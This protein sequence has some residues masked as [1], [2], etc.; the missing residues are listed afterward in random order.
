LL[1]EQ[2]MV[3]AYIEMKLKQRKYKL[4]ADDIGKLYKI[5]KRS[6]PSI[7]VFGEKTKIL[8]ETDDDTEKASCLSA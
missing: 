1:K 8:I 5:N 3:K 2:E 7:P 6:A 4:N